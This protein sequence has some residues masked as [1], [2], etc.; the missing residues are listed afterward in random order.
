[1][2][3][4]PCAQCSCY[5][6]AGCPITW[7]GSPC[8]SWSLTEDR[9]LPCVRPRRVKLSRSSVSTSSVVT[10]RTSPSPA[11]RGLP[12]RGT[13]RVDEVLHPSKACPRRPA[14]PLFRCTVEVVVEV[15]EVVGGDS[16][17]LSS[18]H[19]HANS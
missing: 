14:S 19:C 5:P 11:G 17:P 2:P 15:S 9:P 1:M 4:R 8:A 3:P 16:C 7:R 6:T 18:R 10:V 13:D 12:V